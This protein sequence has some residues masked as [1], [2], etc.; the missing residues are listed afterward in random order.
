MNGLT[1]AHRTLPFNSVVRVTNLK[2]SNSALL[3]I[4]DRGPFV[5]NRIIDLSK[6]AAMKLNVWRPGTALV[7]VEVL[8]TPKPIDRGGKW[9]VQIGGFKDA[10][11]AARLK[12]RLSRRYQTAK[13]LQFT[14]PVGQEWLRVRVLEDDKRRAEELIKETQIEAGIFLVRLD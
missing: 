13:I 5:N 8:E 11:D 14:S 4:T 9:C 1:A 12:D 10:E 6:A 3:R 7:K 2:T